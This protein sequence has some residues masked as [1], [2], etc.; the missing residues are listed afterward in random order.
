M[1]GK[2]KMDMFDTIGELIVKTL[3]RILVIL[4]L[5]L[6]LIYLIYKKSS[7]LQLKNVVRCFTIEFSEWWDIMRG[8]H[9]SDGGI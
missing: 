8:G 5:P 4:V 6:L 9:K 3:T 7:L 2:V 1:V